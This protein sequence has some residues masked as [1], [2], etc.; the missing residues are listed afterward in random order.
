MRVAVVGGGIAG[1]AAAHF[2]QAFADVTLFEASA[3][4][5]GHT[6]THN[7]FVDGAA[8]AVD[9]GF[10]VFN[11]DHYPRF[12]KWLNELGVASKPT[13][14]SFSVSVTDGVEYGTASI[15]GLFCQRRNLLRPSFLGMLRDIRRFYRHAPGLDAN[16]G[17]TLA[18][19]LVDEGYSRAF[20]DEHLVPM[21]AALWSAPRERARDLSIA[22]VAA[23]M[24]NHSLLQLSGRPR[25]RV[26]ES[27]SSAYLTAFETRFGGTLRTAE[28]VRAVLRH[29]QGVTVRTD[30][31]SD[32]FDYVVLACHSDDALALVD[33]TAT[34]RAVLGAI[35]YQANTA[36]LHSDAAA[37]PNNRNAWSSWNVHATAA[38]TYDFTYW[39]NRLQGMGSAPHFFVTLNPQRPLRSVWVER[40]YRHPI[41][42][43]EA[44]AAQRRRHEVS[45]VNRTYYCGAYWGWGFHE[46]GFGSG[47]EAAMQLAEAGRCTWR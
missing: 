11:H 25:W 41:F 2:A 37:M 44:R 4:L 39:M 22:H 31:G 35:D 45:G 40:S 16:D 27:G 28:P 13:D 24:T 8:Y 43:A 38:G 15:G 20:A 36:V 21:C 10:I 42:T 5:G 9:S 23:F 34:E 29:A 7:L 17:R 26:V 46:D 19:F 30:A 18:Q 6:D 14:M 33:A 47:F 32:G 1:V 3:S 12:S